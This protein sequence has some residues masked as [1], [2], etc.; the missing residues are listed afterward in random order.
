MKKKISVLLTTCAFMGAMHSNVYA[1]QVIEKPISNTIIDQSIAAVPVLSTTVS[2]GKMTS[3]TAITALIDSGNSLVVKISD[4]VMSAPSEGEAIPNTDPSLKTYVSGQDLAGVD[5]LKNKYI[6]V[7]EVE[8]NQ[9]IKKFTMITLTAADISSIT[10]PAAPILAMDDKSNND[11]YIL[12]W[13][14]DSQIKYYSVYESPTPQADGR[15]VM[16]VSG[17]VNQLFINKSKLKKGTAYYYYVVATRD[18]LTFSER[19]NEVNFTTPSTVA[20]A[21]TNVQA[22]AGNGQVTITFDVPTDTGGSPIKEYEVLHSGSVVAKGASSPITVTGLTNNTL[23]TFQVRAINGKGVGKTSSESNTVIPTAPPIEEHHKEDKVPTDKWNEP[24]VSLS[25]S[26]SAPNLA[27]PNSYEIL[28]NDKRKLAGTHTVSVRNN[29]TLHNIKI[30]TK[31]LSDFVAKS[32]SHAVI[33]IPIRQKFDVAN[34]ELDGRLLGDLAKKQAVIQLKADHA[35]YE[36]PADQINWQY[37]VDQLGNSLSPEDVQIQI[38]I[39]NGTVEDKKL[40][41][42]AAAS[43]YFTLISEPIHFTVRA[44]HQSAIVEQFN[45]NKFV[46]RDIAIPNSADTKSI[47]TGIVIEPNGSVRQVPTKVSF[48]EGQLVA[49]VSSLFNSTYALISSSVNFEDVS[50]HWAQKAIDDMGTRRIVSGNE[51][52]LFHP[53]E[54]ITRAEFVTILTRGLGLKLEDGKSPFVDVLATDWYNSAVYTAAA[55]QMIKGGGDRR[56]LPENNLTREEAITILQR[57]IDSYNL[58]VKSS[59][60]VEGSY[61]DMKDV[62]S[63]AKEAMINGLQTGIVTG[64]SSTELAPKINLSRAEAVLLVQRL[65]QQADLI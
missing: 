11:F 32:K 30:D 57:A 58:S 18:G 16:K 48:K 22:A 19:S 45:F 27:H 15:L 42:Q 51:S 65:L 54:A 24:S 49:T 8:T 62:S 53:D 12:D 7:Y 2:P 25:N 39:A 35:N 36:V 6:G 59:L 56:F 44:I 13:N 33:T 52:H 34:I 41:A 31:V 9:L 64:V 4:Q 21:P 14:S 47:I 20:N 63:W 37:F 43:G 1:V 55:R 40:T 17:N 23:Y 26:D 46:K 61:T 28:I 3:T 29:Q 10:T 50:D 5:A 60:V 38:E